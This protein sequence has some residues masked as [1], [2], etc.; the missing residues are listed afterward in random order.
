ML[1]AC[2]TNAGHGLVPGLRLSEPQAHAGL[3]GGLG[4]CRHWSPAR[5]EALSQ[6]PSQLL[7]VRAV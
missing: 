2:C 1:N 5:L 3:D 7:P 6:H 4:E